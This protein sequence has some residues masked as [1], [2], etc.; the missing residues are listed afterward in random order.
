MCS[1]VTA[2]SAS[3]VAVAVALGCRR[4]DRS[5]PALAPA[6]PVVATM[7]DTLHSGEALGD[8]FRRHGIVQS[9]LLDVVGLLDLDPRQTQIGWTA[10]FGHLPGDSTAS[11]VTVRTK[12]DEEVRLVRSGEQ[13]SIERIPIVWTS[14]AIRVAGRV[15]TS[16]YDALIAATADTNLTEDQRIG[17]AWDVADV[18]AWQV[19]FTRDVQPGDRF[20]VLVSLET[21]DRGEVRFGEVLASEMS[22]RR[23]RFTAFRFELPDQRIHYY[24]EDGVSLRRAF[25]RAPVEFRRI[26]SRFS[27][28]RL[29]PILRVRRPHVGVDYAAVP[30]TPVR[31]AGDG[32]LLT[33]GWSGD[34]GRLVEL[35]HR[36]GI[37]TRY[38]HLSG[39]GAGLVPGARVL[40][41]DVVGYVGSSG[42]ATAP[43][44]HYEFRQHGVA[45]DPGRAELGEGEPVPAA[46]A[47]AYRAE[48]DRFRA[49]LRPGV[50]P[51]PPHVANGVQ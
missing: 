11:R 37:V 26:A 25:L 13:W 19:D 4:V 2:R 22:V 12:S 16:L 14:Q 43:H 44:L 5:E 31:A 3:L 42:L 41:G 28:S 47:A 38:A 21:S 30:G 29:H 20:T 9:D 36:N 24:D 7:T 51:S 1:A 45:R 50:R 6:P 32:V 40:Q 39:F 48:R 49:L 46:S 27:W 15:T 17:L 23:R 35:G 34:Y 18:F 10:E 8:L 33:A